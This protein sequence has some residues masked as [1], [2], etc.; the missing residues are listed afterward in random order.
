MKVKDVIKYM[1]E[2]N[3]EDRLLIMWWDAD[4]LASPDDIVKNE[5]WNKIIDQTDGYVLMEL[6]MIFMKFLKRHCLILEKEK[7]NKYILR[8]I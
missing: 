7:K 1:K 5:E 3:P 8:R 4:V 2:Y 6:I